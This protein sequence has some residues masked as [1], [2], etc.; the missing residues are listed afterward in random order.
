MDDAVG[1]AYD[2]VSRMLGTYFVFLLSVLLLWYFCG[3]AYCDY[4][5]IFLLSFSF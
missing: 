2:K 1:E 5:L 3:C 4:N